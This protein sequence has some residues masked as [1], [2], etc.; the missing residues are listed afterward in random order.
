MV[1]WEL[2]S[3]LSVEHLPAERSTAPSL[4]PNGAII[5]DSDFVAGGV[6]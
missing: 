1:F 4:R 5:A 3:G 6:D 2:P